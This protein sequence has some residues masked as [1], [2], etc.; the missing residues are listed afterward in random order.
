[1]DAAAEFPGENQR[2]PALATRDVQYGRLRAQSHVRPGKPNLLGARGI[3]D[4]VVSLDQLVPC[5]HPEEAIA[6]VAALAPTTGRRPRRP[7]AGSA[8]ACGDEGAGHA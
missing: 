3:L 6:A 7:I 1:M 2:R 4:V 8:E 5:R